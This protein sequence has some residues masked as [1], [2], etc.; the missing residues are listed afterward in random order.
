MEDRRGS[1]LSA[2]KQFASKCFKGPSKAF[3]FEQKR[4]TSTT[5]SDDDDDDNDDDDD[6]NGNDGDNDD[7][8]GRMLAAA[9]FECQ[10][11]GKLKTRTAA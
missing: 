3:E 9:A 5:R 11:T 6:S 10:K 2:L 7:L 1:F 8:I 4:T